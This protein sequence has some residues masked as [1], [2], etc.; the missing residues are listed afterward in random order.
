MHW[1]KG[2][3]LSPLPS[4]GGTA[5]AVIRLGKALFLLLLS[6]ALLVSSGEATSAIR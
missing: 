1:P 2:S 5:G 3:T 4:Q 6:S